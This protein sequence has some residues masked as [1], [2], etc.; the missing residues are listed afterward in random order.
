MKK[1]GI[2]VAMDSEYRLLLQALRGTNDAQADTLRGTNDTQ[3][4]M[5]RGQVGKCQ[6]AIIKSGIGK[7]NAALQTARLIAGFLPD[8]IINTG[9][10]GGCGPDIHPL[11]VVVGKECCYHDVWCGEPNQKG[12]VQGLPARYEGYATLLE[13]AV[14]LG[15]KPAL[16]CTGDIFASKED[17]QRIQQNFPDCR[18]VDMESAAIAHTCY[19]HQIPF[20]SL[21]V[22]S[23]NADGEDNASQYEDFWSRAPQATF[24]LLHELLTRV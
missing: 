16:I 7:V 22:I 11:D 19:L 12:Q 24:S 17:V 2:I 4:E 8:A 21:R 1:I 6:V 20:L 10:A 18:A 5:A 15:A 13:Q 14:E 23:D 3:I 9:V